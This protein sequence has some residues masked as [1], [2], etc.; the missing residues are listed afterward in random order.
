MVYRAGKDVPPFAWH[1]EG[2]YKFEQVLKNWYIQPGF[3]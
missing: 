3:W 2:L 1:S